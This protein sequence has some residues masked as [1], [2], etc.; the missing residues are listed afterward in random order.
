MKWIRCLL[1]V[2]FVAVTAAMLSPIHL[3]AQAD[4]GAIKGTTQDPTNASVPNAKITL[5]N[6]A[7]GVTATSESGPSGQ[8]SFLNLEP[9]FYTV[10]TEASGFGKS[11]QEHVQVGVG[12]TVPLDIK[13]QPG[14]VQQTVTVSSA[15]A[16]VETQTSDIGTTITPQEI[17]DLP[18]S[19]S[20]DMRNPLNFVFF[21]PGVASSVP[22]PGSGGGAEDYRLHISGS[23]SYSNESY[24][25]GV[26]IMNTDQ[27]GAMGYNHPPI[28]AIGQFK[29]INNNSAAQY[30]L[31][32]GIVSF[33]LKSGTN[34]YHGSAFDYLQNDALN[35]AG[36]TTN[37]LHLKKAPLKQN[38]FG[39]TF[40]GPVWIPKIYNGHDRT[41]FFVDW[42][43]FSY[44]PSSNN[45]TLTTIPNEFRAGNFSQQL[46]PQLTDPGTGAPV[47]DPE[48]RPVY[49]GAI[50]NP[51]SA[52][53]V[54]SPEDGKS[55][56]VRDPFPG[57]I[58]PSGFTGLSAVSQTVLK[59]FPT[60]SNNDLQNNFLR[61]QSSKIDEHRLV[62]KIDEHINEK[63]S[64]SGSVF[65]GG[66]KFS[67]NGGLNLLDAESKSAPTKQ[68]RFTWNWT[69]S[70][71]LLNNLNLGFIRDN[72]FDGPLNPGPGLA[73]LGITGMPP[74]A[75]DSA[76]PGIGLGTVQNGIGGLGG[77]TVA[78]NRYIIN[79]NVTLI[80]GKHTF[81][82]GGEVRWLQ[83]NEHGIPNG[84]FTFEPTQTGLN[85]TGF[86]GGK[87]ITV[88]VGTGAPAASFLLGGMDFVNFGYPIESAFRWWQTGL[89]FQ[90]DWRVTP[91]LTLNLGIRWDLQIPRTD[92]HGEVSTMNPT[93]PNAIAG[94][95][96]GAFT[97]YGT[98]PGRNGKPRIGT[99]DYKGW[100]PRIGFAYSPGDH[101]TAFRG[102]FAITRPL[103][104]DNTVGDIS[105]NQ[106]TS[107]FS[108]AAVLSRPQD[109]LGGPAYYWDNSYP[110][111]GVVQP[112]SN[113]D[114]GIYVG[115]TNP[116]LIHPSAGIPPTQIYWSTQIQHQFA[117][118]IIGNI[119]YVGMHTYHVGTWSKPNEVNPTM[120]RQKYSSAA[121]AAGMP[122][123]E[124]L[125]LPINDSRV[126]AAGILPPWSGFQSTF[127]DG[128]TAA[129][130]LR[131]WPQY[132]DVDNPINPIGSVSYNGLQTSLQKRF[133]QGLTFLLSYTFS[134]TIGNVDSNS[135]PSAGAE[136][137]IFA[138][139]FAQ[140]Y[141]NP[142]GERSVTSSDIPHVVS[143]SYTY[144]LPFGKNKPFLNHGG[145][146]N[147]VV[148]GWSISG[149]HQYQ[150]G[151]PIHIEYDAFGPS[152]PFFAAGDGF[153]FR[154][155]IV[156]NQPFKNP[157]YKKSCS[158][159]TGGTGRNP[160]QFYINPAAFSLPAPGEFGNAPN[161]ISALHMP[162]YINEDLSVSKRTTIH[163][164]LNLQF[165]AN[166]FNA[167]NRV[168][169][170]SG[171]NAQTF[172]IN[173]APPNLSTASLQNS[174]SVFG[175]MTTQQNAPR[176]IQFGMKLEF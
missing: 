170:S 106:Y 123:N 53:T 19:L 29:I 160:C 148:G 25:D 174:Q 71:T 21:T 153:S 102:G 42:T 149:I 4:R 63:H 75:S 117:S 146:V 62:V 126:A 132:G 60:A 36:F 1:S 33:A 97:Y 37:Y 46:G 167:F 147:T 104:N 119:G 94:N 58:I 150:S 81:T 142:H 52:H 65:T 74:L 92:A 115:N 64:I 129:Q 100:Q 139:S 127:G 145:A 2:L 80:R 112:N 67:N 105:G 59:S 154:P 157:A 99:I 32:S 111:S 35:A 26:P 14:Q 84:S 7:T 168:I 6:E 166:F 57:N 141:Y 176:I 120:A 44:R 138:G 124:F 68:F 164:N 161:I 49:S 48:G 31:S 83:R 12:S 54:T 3:H 155:N 55:Y 9:G 39:G 70:P 90:D 10:T 76:F 17:K 169:F 23:V 136:N 144:E 159:P 130:A 134:K 11:V 108:G 103:G 82:M 109:A 47:F 101:K 69:K 56:Q 133:S 171:G 73:A 43:G 8:F 85:G 118:S 16:A 5:R 137:A 22:G 40:G 121:A 88:P 162:A 15:A 98:G 50:Y 51:F 158:H 116:P 95:V 24:I 173:A 122:L 38:E 151:R 156:P 165:Q 78:E 96:P 87:A 114:P 91:N 140:D 107:G 131:P 79:D 175:I 128:A 113:L 27:P 66:Y 18:V 86:A 28:D 72:F 20:A 110:A 135:G 152:N 41:F 125:T 45:A 89:F 30:G 13:L 93:L 34:S 163:E 77:S 172:I 143:L 61:L